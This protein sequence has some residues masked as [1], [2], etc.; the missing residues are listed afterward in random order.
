M[1]NDKKYAGWT[2]YETWAVAL[3]IN[4]EEETYKWSREQAWA[5]LKSHD[6]R[7]TANY[8]LADVLKNEMGES[9]P[10][11]K[12]VWADLLNAAFSEVDWYEIAESFIADVRE[13]RSV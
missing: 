1:E 9:M 6:G 12:G 10:Q 8:K 13:A 11:V 3:W 5:V 7:D 4:N 2:N